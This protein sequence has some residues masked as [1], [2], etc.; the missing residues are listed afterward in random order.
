MGKRVSA[1]AVGLASA[2]L[3][4]G[5]AEPPTARV[6]AAKQG[7]QA[8]AE[9]A[10]TY[11]AEEYQ[12][13]T[14]TASEL[15]AELEAQAEGFAPF[16]SY[17]RAEELVG[18]LE[19]ATAKVRQA[20]TDEQERLRTE[21]AQVVADARR[22][23]TEAQQSLEAVPARDMPADQ[24]PGWHADLAQVETSLSQSET[25]LASG[26]LHDARREAETA[27]NTAT[28]VSTAVTA[29]QEELQQAREEA[30]AR[31]AR[32]DITMPRAVLANGEPLAAGAYRL[33]LGEVGPPVAGEGEE[34]GRWIEF[35][36]DGTVAGR[37]LAVVIPDSEIKEIAESSPPRNAV[38]VDQLRGG[39]YVR[40]WLNRDG[41]NYLVHMP[42]QSRG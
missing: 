33:Q 42:I 4:W 5:C 39:E 14:T 12:A 13:A 16:R 40:V 20:I 2:I 36:R 38:R 37:G 19:A 22:A 7:L 32:G 35:L 24:E 31:A 9:D 27:L 3:A 15:D 1:V 6:E 30:R 21:A 10:K 34:P 17:E 18:S 26:Q 8:V 29:L 41:V 25:L 11:A 28:S 23:L